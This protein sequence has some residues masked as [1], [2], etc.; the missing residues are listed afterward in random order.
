MIL[1]RRHLTLENSE[2]GRGNFGSVSRG[3]LSIP[4]N[5]DITVAVKRVKKSNEQISLLEEIVLMSALKSHPNI[6]NM[7]GAVTHPEIMILVEFCPLGNLKDFLIN[8]NT[9]FGSLNNKGLKK[10]DGIAVPKPGGFEEINQYQS[11]PIYQVAY[12]LQTDNLVE[13]AIQ[14]ASGMKFLATRR[15]IHRDLAARNVLLVTPTTV[16]IC[17]FGLSKNCYDLPEVI[18][19]KKKSSPLPYKWMAIESI[20][21]KVYSTKSDVW[22]YGIVLWELFTLGQ[23]PYPDQVIDKTFLDFLEQGYRLA[24]PELA[25]KRVAQIMVSCWSESPEE[26]PDFDQIYQSLIDVA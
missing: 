9:N 3:T 24:T 6:V 19:R 8:N 22:S 21:S 18:Y 25:P 15:I 11:N 16:K 10:F 17:D 1:D 23:D 26:R 2:I 13:I 5:Q 7:I 4:G 14:I 20:V 12:E